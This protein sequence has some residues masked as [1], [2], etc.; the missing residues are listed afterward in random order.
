MGNSG[1]ANG[2]E[3]S[4]MNESIFM[5]LSAFSG[6]QEGLDLSSFISQY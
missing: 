6:V 1:V 3:V 2:Y 4:A 5:N